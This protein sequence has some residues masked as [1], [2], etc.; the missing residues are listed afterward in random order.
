MRILLDESVPEKLGKRL[1][2]HSFSTV[3]RQGWASIKWSCPC[4]TEHVLYATQRRLFESNSTNLLNQLSS[5]L[6]RR[7]HFQT[8]IWVCLIA[9]FERSRQLLQ[10]GAAIAEIHPTDVIAIE[11][12][13]R[14]CALR[15]K[16][17]PRFG[18]SEQR[19]GCG[20]HGLFAQIVHVY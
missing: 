14:D 5:E 4:T 19:G 17:S 2:G 6:A 15:G 1:V 10:H 8:R 7:R 12:V 13:G 3:Q 16:L 9:V 20:V 18:R 11:G